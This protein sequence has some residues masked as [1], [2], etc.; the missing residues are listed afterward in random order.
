MTDRQLLLR[1]RGFWENVRQF[2]P[3]LS[4]FCLFVFVFVFLFCFFL[5]FFFFF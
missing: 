3:R 5:L 2:I 1:V 4:V